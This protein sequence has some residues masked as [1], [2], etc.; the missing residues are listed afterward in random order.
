MVDGKEKPISRNKYYVPG[1]VLR[2]KFDNQNPIAYGMPAEGFVFFDNNP[3]FD[4]ATDTAMK[5][6]PV[7]SFTSKTP[8]FSGW[9]WGQQYLDGGK[10][11]AETS[12]GA[13]KIVLLA[14][15]PT[16][17]GTP[18]STFKLFFNGLYYGSAKEIAS[19]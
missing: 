11:A 14:F 10:I 17:R 4:V 16:F 6:N 9:A 13:G 12:L 18:H 8:L 19:P 15:E 5:I 7:V 3:V 2:A 1:S